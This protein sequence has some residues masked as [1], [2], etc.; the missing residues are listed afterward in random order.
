MI[1]EYTVTV[2]LAIPAVCALHL[3][4]VPAGARVR[5]PRGVREGAALAL[6]PAA[7]GAR[8]GQVAERAK[9]LACSGFSDRFSW[10]AQIQQLSRW[11]EKFGRQRSLYL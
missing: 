6:A 7:R 9:A 4:S 3:F 5:A 2:A 1:R 11:R 10:T 8:G